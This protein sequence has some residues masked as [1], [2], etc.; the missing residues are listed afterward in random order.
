MIINLRW[1]LSSNNPQKYVVDK[2]PIMNCSKKLISQIL[3]ASVHNS[4]GRIAAIKGE[5]QRALKYFE[6]AIAA[7]ELRL[8]TQ[9]RLGEQLG[10]LGLSGGAVQLTANA[11]V[12]GIAATQTLSVKHPQQTNPN[13][14]QDFN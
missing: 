6:N 5:G 10:Q 9:A 13:P 11:S 4:L 7:S 14:S 12:N 8:L 2:H 1:R 3:I